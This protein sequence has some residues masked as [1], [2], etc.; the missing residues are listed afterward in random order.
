[1][2]RTWPI[3]AKTTQTVTN[4]FFIGR[5]KPKWWATTREEALPQQPSCTGSA[6]LLSLGLICLM[7]YNSFIPFL[8]GE[9]LQMC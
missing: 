4:C 9:N 1:M 3:C 6:A 8:P 2:F 5:H 7:D